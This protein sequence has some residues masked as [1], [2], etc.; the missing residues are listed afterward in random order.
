[1]AGSDTAPPYTTVLRTLAPA[2]RNERPPGDRT[3]PELTAEV[4][5]D[6][7]SR[8]VVEAARYASGS[9]TG[10]ACKEPWP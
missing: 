4:W 1:M 8:V 7:A 5:G 6:G 2:C 3:D 10:S 9:R